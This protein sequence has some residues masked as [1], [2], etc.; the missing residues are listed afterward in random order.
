M[1]GLGGVWDWAEWERAMGAFC[2]QDWREIESKLHGGSEVEISRLQM[3]CFKGAWISNVLHDGIG[4]PRLVDAGGNDTLTGGETGDTNAEAERRAKEKGLF[5][6]VSKHKPHFQSMDEVDETA[7]SWTLGKIVIEASK[8]VGPTPAPGIRLGNLRIPMHLSEL[9]GLMW[10]YIFVFMALIILLFSTVRRRRLLRRFRLPCL[11]AERDEESGEKRS[12]KLALW[13]RRMANG[14]R[15]T[16]V[17]LRRH[18]SMPLSSTASWSQP[19]SPSTFTPM[20]QPPSPRAS[21][22]HGTPRPRPSPRPRNSGTNPPFLSANS[23]GWNDPPMGLFAPDDDEEWRPAPGEKTL[24]RQ[25]SRVNLSE[26][27]GVA[28]RSASRG[29]TPLIG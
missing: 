7:I 13:S 2:A 9:T 12:S 25:S 4:I 5:T 3:Q 19:S 14:F 24:S 22:A 11:E 28:Q 1:L 27:G 16:R 18:A 23:G 6:K 29:N 10:G 17:P 8:A 20:D 21:S 26:F 15:R